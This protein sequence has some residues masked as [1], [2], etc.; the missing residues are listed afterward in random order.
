LKKLNKKKIDIQW[1]NKGEKKNKYNEDCIFDE[2]SMYPIFILRR[3]SLRI[4]IEV[5]G[6]FMIIKKSSFEH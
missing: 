1:Y 3:L 4:K 2:K 6:L 5:Y